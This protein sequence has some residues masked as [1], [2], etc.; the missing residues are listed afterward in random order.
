MASI[1]R[2]RMLATTLDITPNEAERHG[3][4]LNHDGV[5][6]S[7]FE[8]LA[9]PDIDVPRLMTVW[10]ELGLI[11]RFAAEQI[12]I[13]AKYAVYLDRQEADIA[14]VKKDDLISLPADLD[15]SAIDGLSNEIRE[16][17]R[18]SRPATLGQAS[19]LEGMT[20]A[21]LALL[22]A[23]AKRKPKAAA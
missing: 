6:R 17:L 11:D 7:A 15:Y 5:R 23:E 1:D 22:L 9:R 20:P 16:R 10:P 21:A 2:G 8:L 14:C 18:A 19:R 12:E 3:I 4:H 13:D